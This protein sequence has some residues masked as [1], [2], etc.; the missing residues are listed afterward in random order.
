MRVVGGLHFAK[1]SMSVRYGAN[2]VCG[3]TG[4]GKTYCWGVNDFGQLGVGT[5]AIDQCRG[6]T[7]CSPIPLQVKGGLTFTNVNPNVHNTC[8]VTVGKKAYCWGANSF[9]QLG[10]GT[11]NGSS[12]PV[13]VKGNLAFDSVSPGGY[14]A[15][16]YACG[17][18]HGKAYCWGAKA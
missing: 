5:M 4:A 7:P 1:L 14:G 11:K 10:N 12:V 8:A 16:K 2:H 18:V 6:S 3:I 13:A 17:L 15:Q 9:G